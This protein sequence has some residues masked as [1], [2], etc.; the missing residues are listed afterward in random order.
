MFFPKRG[1]QAPA[2]FLPTTACKDSPP[3]YPSLTQ[4]GQHLENTFKN[5]LFF[6]KLGI[7]VPAACLPTTTC[8]KSLPNY[9]FLTK[10]DK[11]SKN[12]P[13]N[14][15]FF[16]SEVFKRLRRFSRQPHANISSVF[17][18]LTFE[19]DRNGRLFEKEPE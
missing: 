7:Q 4:N 13:K 11:P 15:Q 8:K 9:S 12:T 18:L 2:A 10:N 3:N 17:D 14:D 5:E 19:P 16:K 6:S 1:P